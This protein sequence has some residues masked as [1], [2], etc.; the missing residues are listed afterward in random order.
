[1]IRA[2]LIY[3]AGAFVALALLTAFHHVM[4]RE[5]IDQWERASYL[6]WQ[7]QCKTP[8]YELLCTRR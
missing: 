3:G 5:K 7:G 6:H 4:E 1:M 8:A 2:G